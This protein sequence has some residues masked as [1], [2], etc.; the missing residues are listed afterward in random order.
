MLKSPPAPLTIVDVR[1]PDEFAA[2]HL[3]GAIEIDLNG[4]S[5][6]TEVAKLDRNGVYFVYCHSGHRSATAVAYLQQ[7][8]FTS[9]YELQGG[10]VAWQRAGLPVT[11]A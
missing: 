11:T 8:G 1:T 9:I 2:G 5:F 7:A 4:P 6:A 3:A 10:I